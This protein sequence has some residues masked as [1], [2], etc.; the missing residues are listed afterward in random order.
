[1]SLR[2]CN[3]A[4]G[5]M[6]CQD[7]DGLTMLFVCQL[8]SRRAH[9]CNTQQRNNRHQWHSVAEIRAHLRAQYGD[10]AVS[11]NNKNEY[12]EIFKKGWT[13]ANDAKCSGYP[14][15]SLT[16]EKLQETIAMVL[17]DRICH[18]NHTKIKYQPRATIFN[19]V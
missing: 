11:Q 7:T 14:S 13:S 19:S 4:T 1:M 17:R 16:T 15:Q 3:T 12:T 10:N 8:L 2:V 6:M 9:G 18:R 5:Y